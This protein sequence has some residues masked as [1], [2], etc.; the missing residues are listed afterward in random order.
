[1][2]ALKLFSENKILLI[3][4]KEDKIN[5]NIAYELEDLYC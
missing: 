2:N 3:K 5:G 1:M 4:M